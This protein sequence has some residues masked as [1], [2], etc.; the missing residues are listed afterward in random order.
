MPTKNKKIIVANWKMNPVSFQEAQ[1][2]LKNTIK[3]IKMSK[4]FETV[5]CVPFV[6]IE[7]IGHLLKNKQG[8]Y[9]GAQDAFWESE[10]EAFTGE[11]SPLM[12]KN[13]GVQYVILG[14]SERRRW[15]QENNE[16]INKKIK[17]S[18]GV[19]LK[20][21]LCVGEWNRQDANYVDFV[22]DQLKSATKGLSVRDLNNL[23]V[24]Y[25]PVWAIGSSLSDTPDDAMSMAILIKK[26]ISNQFSKKRPIKVKV[27]YGGSVN[28]ENARK[29]LKQESIDGALVG[30]ASLDP[31]S[32]AEIIKSF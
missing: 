28:S 6:W 19:G 8:Y 4:K 30:R 14:H 11:I 18:L 9:L 22:I 29:F 2:I 17:S 13:L 32:F 24:A 26:T 7:K 31:K 3:L 23:I 10:S 27:L 16:M 20:V 21:I 5:F 15:L 1:K 25:E 12:L